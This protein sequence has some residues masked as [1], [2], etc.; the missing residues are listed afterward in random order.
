MTN[1]PGFAQKTRGSPREGEGRGNTSD[2][3]RGRRR[4]TLVA[5]AETRGNLRALGTTGRPFRDPQGS[6]RVGLI[7]EMPDIDSGPRIHAI[8]AGGRCDE[9][10][11]RSARNHLG[12]QREIAPVAARGNHRAA[13]AALTFRATPFR[14]HRVVRRRAHVNTTPPTEG[15][16][17]GGRYKRHEIRQSQ[18]SEC[19]RSRCRSLNRARR[20]ARR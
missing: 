7:A 1:S 13:G 12:A 2:I 3:P 20:G 14:S 4:R 17:H 5:F 19:W 8:R 10:R 11:R 15:R 18:A 9:A 6:N 16:S